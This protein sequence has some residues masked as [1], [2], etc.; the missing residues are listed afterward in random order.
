[1]QYEDLERR[2]LAEFD[3]KEDNLRFYRITE[4][5]RLRVKE[6]GNFRAKD[7]DAPLVA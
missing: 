4:P 3:E 7:F 5:A 1:M 6:H 2:L